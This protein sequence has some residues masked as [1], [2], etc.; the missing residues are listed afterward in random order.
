MAVF[1]EMMRLRCCRGICFAEVVKEDLGIGIGK[2]ELLGSF[3]TSEIKWD[4]RHAR[5]VWCERFSVSSRDW[6]LVWFAVLLV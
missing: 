2:G 1:A 6:N 4:H 3:F 5:D